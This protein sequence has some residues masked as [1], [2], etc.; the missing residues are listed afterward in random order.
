MATASRALASRRPVSVT[1]SVEGGRRAALTVVPRRRRTVGVVVSVA[2]FVALA[3][4]GAA[5]SQVY[6]ARGQLAID[7]LDRQIRDT[8]E[9][10]EQLRLERA[11]LR[12][13]GRL[14]AV[15]EQWNL[16]PDGDAT[17]MVL[18]PDVI[19]TMRRSSALLDP[20][21]GSEAALLEQFRTVKALQVG[22]P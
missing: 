7:Q 9:R 21:Y 11:E 22:A 6:L 3:M 19:A 18:S 16:Q 12:S 10:Y 15:A 14:Q 8:T 20:A 5:A 2:S 17:F 4:L 1:P 13:P